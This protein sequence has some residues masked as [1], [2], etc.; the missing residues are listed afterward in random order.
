MT[1]H[2]SS[3]VSNK[4]DLVKNLFTVFRLEAKLAQLSI[5]PLILNI[6]ILFVI[7]M[8]IWCGLMILGGYLVMILGASLIKALILTLCFNLLLL[9]G[10]IKYLSFNANNISFKQTRAYFSSKEN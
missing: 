3:F 9:L 8:T 5:V 2:L 1:E 7:M 10:L 6:I 4:I